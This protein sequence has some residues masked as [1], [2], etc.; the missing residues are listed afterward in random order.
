MSNISDYPLSSSYIS[1]PTVSPDRGYVFTALPPGSA[2]DA[3]KEVLIKAMIAWMR[4][5]S[6]FAGSVG[7]RLQITRVNIVPSPDGNEKKKGAEVTCEVVV[8]EGKS[9]SYLPLTGV[10]RDLTRC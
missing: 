5:S 10:N 9:Q 2:S 3:E 7:Q 8:Q 6:W 4:K 1:Y